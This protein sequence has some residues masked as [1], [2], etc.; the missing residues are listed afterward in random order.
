MVYQSRNSAHATD[1]AQYEKTRLN[2]PLTSQVSWKNSCQKTRLR[3]AEAASSNR[4]RWL[5]ISVCEG[6]RENG[7]GIMCRKRT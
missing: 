6:V 2:G 1:E 3:W 5:F 7:R 4:H